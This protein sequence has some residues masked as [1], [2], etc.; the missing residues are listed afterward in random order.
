MTV[1]WRTAEV[2][3]DFLAACPPGVRVIVVD[4]ASPDG[5]PAIVRAARPEARVVETSHN[6]NFGPGYNLEFIKPRQNSP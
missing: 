6:L 2:I 3:R 5:T 4:N 1:T